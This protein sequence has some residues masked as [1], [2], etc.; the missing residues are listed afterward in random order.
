MAN[1]DNIP[2]DDMQ[3]LLRFGNGK[4][5]ESAFL[6]LQ[7]TDADAARRWLEGAPISNA[8]AQD[9]PPETSLQIAFSA[10]GLSVLGLDDTTVEQ[11][12]DEFL[13]GMSSDHSRSRRLGDTGDNAPRNWLWGGPAQQA[14]HVLLLLYAKSGGLA[15]WRDQVTQGDFNTGFTLQR[16]LPTA[17][18]EAREPF[19]FIDGISQPKIDWAQLQSTDQHE[20][21]SYSNRLALGDIVL[22]YR[23]EYGLYTDRPLINRQNDPNAVFLP[24]AEDMPEKQDFGRNGCYL[25]IRQLQQDVPGFWRYVDKATGHDP[26]KRETLAASMVGRRRDGT[27]LVES[28]TQDIPGISPGSAKNRFTYESD[29]LGQRCPIGAHIRR[30]NPRNGDYPPGVTGLLS[31]L[32]RALGFG[33]SHPEADLVASTRFHRLLR[34]GRN[35]GPMLTPEEA[36][37]PDAPAA[38]RGLQFICLVSNITRQFE[39]V[40]NAWSISSKFGGVQNERDP[41]IGTRDPLLDG[42]GTDQF[43]RPDEFGPTQAVGGMPQF[44]TVKGG[45]YFFMPGLRAIRYLA[46]QKTPS[47]DTP[48]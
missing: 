2:F 19:G 46:R 3:V 10:Q 41:I 43:R 36:I 34:R 39:F 24:K 30:T 23:N 9:S 17:A 16:Q 37:A 1:D 11:F 42:T 7:V 8:V 14:P 32:V 38:E 13:V 4:L 48:S 15:A 21:D 18:L 31:R 25:V 26:R 29:P 28:S 40:Q 33:L 20:R 45:G 5:T 27:P 35:Y 47:S 44:V 12:S 22:G 6:L